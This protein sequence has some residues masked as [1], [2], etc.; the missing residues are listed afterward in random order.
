MPRASARQDPVRSMHS[1]SAAL[2]FVNYQFTEFCHAEARGISENRCVVQLLK[3]INLHHIHIRYNHHTPILL[4]LVQDRHLFQNI[5][6]A[7]HDRAGIA[8]QFE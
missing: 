8:W 4:I 7:L 2:T 3:L 6:F 5:F 1:E